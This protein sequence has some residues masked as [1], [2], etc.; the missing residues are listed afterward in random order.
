MADVNHDE[1]VSNHTACAKKLAEILVCRALARPRPKDTTRN[2]LLTKAIE[3]VTKLD[4]TLEP[5]LS[6]IVSET[7]KGTSTD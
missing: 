5:K 1:L 3:Q 2:E 4:A 7:Q 6:M